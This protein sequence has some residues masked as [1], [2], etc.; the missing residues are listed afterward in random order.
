[1]N[2]KYAVIE[3]GFVSNIIIWDGIQNLGELESN[4]VLLPEYFVN[5]GFQYV[6]GV[7]SEVVVP[8]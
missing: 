3:N 1:M 2:A 7:F 8:E 4:L 6:D 5:I